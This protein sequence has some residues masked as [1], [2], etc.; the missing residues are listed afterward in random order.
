[1]GIETVDKGSGLSHAPCTCQP[2]VVLVLLLGISRRCIPPPRTALFFTYSLHTHLSLSHRR[3][4]LVL[5][6]TPGSYSRWLPRSRS[7][8][9]PCTATSR[10]WYVAIVLKWGAGAGC[11]TAPHSMAS[12]GLRTF[13]NRDEQADAELEGIKEAG[14]DAKLFQYVFPSPHL[15]NRPLLVRNC[16]RKCHITIPHLP[17]DHQLTPSQ[18]RRDPPPR[19]P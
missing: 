16:I 6:D 18:S 8:T 1:M 12:F 2:P 15:Q 13:A 7:F 4:L 10:R 5:C 14:G 19:R 9:T 17:Q 11:E 3:T